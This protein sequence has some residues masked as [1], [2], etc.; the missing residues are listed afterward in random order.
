MTS[1]SMKSAESSSNCVKLIQILFTVTSTLA[2]I[3]EFQVIS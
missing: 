1:F 2:L 3:Y